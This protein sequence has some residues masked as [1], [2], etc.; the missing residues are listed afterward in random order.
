MP[1]LASKPHARPEFDPE[2]P[3]D[4]RSL[5][6]MEEIEET[7]SS[8]TMRPPRPSAQPV[9][10]PLK[11]VIAEYKHQAQTITCV[12]GWH[13]RSSSPDGRTSEWTAHL[14]ANRTKPR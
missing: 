13:G 10:E 11:H 7:M 9:N 12:C 1:F 14:A 5:P 8:G 2:P 6:E 4:G 3:C